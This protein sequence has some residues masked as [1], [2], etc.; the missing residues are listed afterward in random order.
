V[1]SASSKYKLVESAYAG[2]PFPFRKIGSLIVE[3]RCDVVVGITDRVDL[4]C[5][6]F[7]PAYDALFQV[8]GINVEALMTRRIM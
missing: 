7:G 6:S 2:A 8:G 4:A 1:P 5:R 3:T